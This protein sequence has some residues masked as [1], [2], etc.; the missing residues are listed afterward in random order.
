M[1]TDS[2]IL[3]LA[4]ELWAIYHCKVCCDVITS[5]KTYNK[6]S[7]TEISPPLVHTKFK[8]VT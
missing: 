4:E 8:S 6:G 3:H 2:T 7:V 5:K 1:E